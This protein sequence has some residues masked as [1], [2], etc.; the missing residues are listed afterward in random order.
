MKADEHKGGRRGSSEERMEK[1]E[2]RHLPSP[3]CPQI[4][5][6]L[7]LLDSLQWS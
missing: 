6:K 4:H 5:H 1:G 7:S 2:E 3:L